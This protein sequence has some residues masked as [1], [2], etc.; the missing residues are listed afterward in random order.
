[1]SEDVFPE[2]SIIAYWV[3][4][5]YLSLFRLKLAFMLG[6]RSFGAEH[7]VRLEL[8]TTAPLMDGIGPV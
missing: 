7:G 8:S 4:L 2:T 3:F 6:R 1:M 5:G